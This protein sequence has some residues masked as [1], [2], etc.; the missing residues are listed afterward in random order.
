[1]PKVSV[2]I[3]TYNRP[4]QIGPTIESLLEQTFNDFE[5]LLVDN[6][7]HNSGFDV[8]KHL[9]PKS[10]GRLKLYHEPIQGKSH[11]VN[12]GIN[13]S[14]GRIIALTDDDVI[15]DRNWLS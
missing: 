3:S 9:I 2:I 6:S 4:D 1:M 8:I 10:Q 7:D 15:V 13:E 11:A 14:Q 12:R 5:I